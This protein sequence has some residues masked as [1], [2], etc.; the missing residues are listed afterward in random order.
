[1]H[2]YAHAPIQSPGLGVEDIGPNV[3]FVPVSVSWYAA[4]TNYHKPG[5]LKQQKSFCRSPGGQR[6]KSKTH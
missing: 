6:P 3:N 2:K 1:M 4:V 5:G